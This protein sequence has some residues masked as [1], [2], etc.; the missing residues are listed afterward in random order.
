[1]KK[2]NILLSAIILIFATGCNQSVNTGFSVNDFIKV[3]DQYENQ[4][5]D[6]KGIINYKY[7]CPPC[8]K[9][10]LCKP[11]ANPNIALADQ[12]GSL[13]AKS[14]IIIN[15]FKDEEVYQNLSLGEKITVNIKYNAENLGGASNMNGYFV[16]NEFIIDTK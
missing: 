1:M 6:I 12:K 5:V 9:G 16:Y 4:Y 15:F 10:Y 8:P 11:C 14:N 2:T 3:K 13:D 7:E